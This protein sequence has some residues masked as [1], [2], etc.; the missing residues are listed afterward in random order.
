MEWELEY[1]DW[2]ALLSATL[3]VIA[4]CAADSVPDEVAD[5]LLYVLARDNEGE[6]IR[7]ALAKAPGLLAQ[8]GQHAVSVADTEAKW[9][10]AVSIAEAR[11]ANAAEL[12]RPFL[13]DDSEY[14]R[15]RTLLALAK[16]APQQAEALALRDL[17][18]EFEY[19]RLAALDVLSQVGSEHLDRV[20]DRLAHDAS[21][22]VRTRVQE[23]RRK[24]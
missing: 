12:M 7:E 4:A 18:D 5:D 9:Q 10:I 23:M 16:I 3:D 1:E 24:G 15:R 20:L 2:D 19:T 11:L 6:V 21:Q 8:L 22:H 14:V 13:D 17:D